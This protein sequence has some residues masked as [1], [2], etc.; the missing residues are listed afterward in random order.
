LK[1]FNALTLEINPEKTHFMLLS[2]YQ[3]AGQNRDIKI[4][5]KSFENVSEFRYLGTTIK[6]TI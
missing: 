4:A 1:E 6:I 2:Q 3:N 5:D